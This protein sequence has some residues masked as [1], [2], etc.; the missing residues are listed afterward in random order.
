MS[1]QARIYQLE[2]TNHCNARCD[3]CPH[4]KMTREKGFVSMATVD[5]VV[6]NCLET[7]QKYIALHHMGEP[8][9]HPNI[10]SII[11]KF[12]R[13][14]ISTEL[15]TNG[16]LLKEKGMEILYNKV[17]LV[18]IAVDYFYQTEG[19]LQIVENFLFD[20][21]NFPDTKIRIHSVVGNDLSRFEKFMVFDNIVLENKV[22][23][24][25]GGQV[26]GDSKLTPGNTCYF[27]EYNYVVALWDGTLVTCCL[28]FDGSYP[29]RNIADIA[30][31]T[32]KPCKLCK[33]CSKLQFADGGGW[34]K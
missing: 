1:K 33:T 28:D 16:M 11:W 4:G 13:D 9:L 27:Q 14:N 22:F 24:N 30:K 8:L 26:D 12:T 18:R 19:F 34:T 17:S 10:G 23:D 2:T 20:A 6:S 32:N 25:W 7:N 21:V 5:K 3:Y 15:S 29:L 31:I